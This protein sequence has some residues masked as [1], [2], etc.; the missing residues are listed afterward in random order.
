[1]KKGKL[2]ALMLAIAL[3]LSACAQAELPENPPEEVTAPAEEVPVQEEVPAAE[4]P[5]DLEVITVSESEENL[6]APKGLITNAEDMPRI[7]GSTACIPLMLKV[8]EKACGLDEEEAQPYFTA[9]G[10]QNCWNHLYQYDA[11]LVLAYEIPEE[12]EEQYDRNLLDITPIGR[13][14]LVFLVNERNPITNLTQQQLIDIYTGKITNWAQV[15]GDDEEIIPIQRDAS[16]GSQTLFRKLLMKDVEPMEVPL[17]Y[18]I[19]MMDELV[20]EIANYDNSKN[21][22]GFSVYYYVSQMKNEPGIRLLSVDGVAPTNETI[23]DGTYPLTNDFFA[24]IRTGTQK[25]GTR[26]LYDWICSEEGKQCLI[27]AGY[28]PA[29]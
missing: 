27:D 28:V 21:D 12:T 26:L 8:L 19:T 9:S 17:E 29:D 6:T 24:A 16:S 15:G 1:M 2:L 11:D 23:A 14:A 25:K 10:T 20:E 13:D 5:N 18:Q 22:L 3:L 4:E 7:D